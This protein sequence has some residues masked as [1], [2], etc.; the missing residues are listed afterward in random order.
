MKVVYITVVFVVL[1]YFSVSIR[2]IFQDILQVYKG[3]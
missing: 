1:S 2:L 3:N